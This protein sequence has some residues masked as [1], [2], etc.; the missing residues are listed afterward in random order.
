MADTYGNKITHEC[1]YAQ[2]KY[3]MASEV[4]REQV[5][6][7]R[8]LNGYGSVQQLQQARGQ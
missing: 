4:W 7:K 3:L 5:A 6:K 2:A 1:V 8:F